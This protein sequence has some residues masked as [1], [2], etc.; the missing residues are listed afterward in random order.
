LPLRPEVTISLGKPFHG[1]N[2]IPKN[3]GGRCREKRTLPR[4]NNLFSRQKI[5]FTALTSGGRVQ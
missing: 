4:P 1:D 2:N 5:S 3:V